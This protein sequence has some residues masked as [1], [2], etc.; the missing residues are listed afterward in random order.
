MKII[1]LSILSLLCLVSLNIFA[2]QQIDTIVKTKSGEIMKVDTRIDNMHYWKK[3][4]SKGIVPKSPEVI[5][6]QGIFSSSL[7]KALSV[8]TTDSPDVPVTSINSTQSENSIFVNPTDN[9]KVINSNNS[10]Q[11]PV[12]TLYGS[13]YFYSN[14]E[15]L[16]WSGIVEGAGGSNS[17]DPA[18]AIGL[19][20]RMYIGFIHDNY[21]Q[22]VSYSADNGLTWTSVQAGP[23]PGNDGMLDKNH[24][25]IDNSPT[26]IYEGNVYDAWT[27]FGGANDSEIEIVKTSDG[28]LTYSTPVAISTAVNA[29]SHNQGVNIQTGPAGQVYVTWSIY[30]DWAGNGYE[31]ALGF[32]KSVD[33]GVT[34][35]PASRIIT[36]I[37]GI[38]NGL[39]K[40]QRVNSFPSMAVDL[41]DGTIYIVW[42]NF[43]VPGTNSG[44]N[45]SIYMIKST[46]EG[47]TW[48]TPARINDGQFADGKEAYFPWITCD[49]VTGTLSVIYYE[50]KNVTESQVET[51]VSNSYDSGV[52]WESFK[53]SDVAF[54]PTPIAGL[55]SSYMGD[56]LGISAYNS[57]VYPVWTDNRNGEAMAYVSPFETNNRPRPQNLNVV[58]NSTNGQAD[59]TWQFPT[60]RVFQYFNIYRNNV[61]IG[62]TTNLTYT[63]NLPTFGYYT[64]K[65]TAMHDDGESG[66]SNKNIRWG[67][68]IIEVNPTSLSQELGYYETATQS[69][70][71]INTGQLDLTFGTETNV[72]LLDYC[73]SDGGCDEFISNVTFGEINNTSQ[74]SGYVN[75]TEFSTDIF[76]GVEEIITVTNGNPYTDDICAIWIDWNQDGDFN[77]TYE[78]IEMT[79]A[80]G[81]GPYTAT[82]TPPQSALNGATTMRVRID[83]SNDNPTPCDNTTYGEVEDYTVIVNNWLNTD[84]FSGTITPSQSQTFDVNFSSVG[85][86]NGVYTSDLKITNNSDNNTSV[87]LP[88]TLTVTGSFPLI[89]D[90]VAS[91]SII[92]ANGTSEITGNVSGGDQT[93]SFSWTSE[94]SGFTSSD[95]DISVSPAV[96]TIYTL[97]ATDG[98]QLI[99]KSVNVEVSPVPNIPAKPTGPVS[100]NSNAV[101]STYNTTGTSTATSYVWNITP[102]EAGTISGTSKQAVVDWNNSFAGI[103]GISV[104]GINDCGEG[105]FSTSLN[106]NVTITGIE[107]TSD[108]LSF[109]IY[110]NPNNGT[111]ILELNTVDEEI[112]DVYIYNS[113]GAQVYT[114][115][116]VNVW[117]K[118][119]WIVDI[120]NYEVGVYFVNIEGKSKKYIAKFIVE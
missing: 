107:K 56:Y 40:N 117:A 22:G 95:E 25:W 70:T 36:N 44:T 58:L 92:C 116:D 46:D 15:G 39:Q 103:A 83:Y 120:K 110:P 111:F 12:G 77:D 23:P 98:F 38:R 85:I 84:N 50:D 89:V 20:G 5:V 91:P 35:L 27:N 78:E 53:I 112:V 52:T 7:I 4:S 43:G 2:Q 32:A 21:G 11:N 100:V 75:Y 63:D 9:T 104:K 82:I 97:E 45:S 115:T 54:T 67:T 73:E 87:I 69:F 59:L 101:N 96:T 79:N 17:G 114:K 29:G 16:T 113:A 81:V 64:Y 51:W 65:V 90:P 68:I 66:S 8:T 62:S 48:S 86:F 88:L 72:T 42:T 49:P 10:T 18:T 47:A 76:T 60:T 106:V 30:D 118:N 33:G 13:N 57:V 26:S 55:A 34:Y 3:L 61:F 71:I 41:S 19:D 93:Y 119:S 1:K 94:P 14:D 37:K 74:C 24:L 108:N 6:P 28:G 80:I 109:A 99:K 102:S 31:E 105:S